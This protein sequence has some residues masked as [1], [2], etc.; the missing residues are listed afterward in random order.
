MPSAHLGDSHGVSGVWVRSAAVAWH[1]C[2]HHPSSL[3][4][5]PVCDSP[6]G[7]G[8]GS[9][10]L[11]PACVFLAEREDILGA[12]LGASRHLHAA[13]CCRAGLFF[14]GVKF[15]FGSC[16]GVREE[17]GDASVLQSGA[18]HLSTG[19]CFQVSVPGW[20]CGRLPGH[21]YLL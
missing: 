12:G 14:P 10:Q 19:E 4:A 9:C 2:P 7:E 20:E 15:P 18:A 16:W 8:W 17:Q 1:C 5:S 13:A 21:C 6:A 3:S 11:N